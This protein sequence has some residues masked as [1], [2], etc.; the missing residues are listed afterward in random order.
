MYNNKLKAKHW[1]FVVVYCSTSVKTASSVLHKD[2]HSNMWCVVPLRKEKMF[3][4]NIRKVTKKWSL[5]SFRGVNYQ[6]ISYNTNEFS[7]SS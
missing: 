5:G 4:S 1:T 6:H 2:T 7:A 3:D